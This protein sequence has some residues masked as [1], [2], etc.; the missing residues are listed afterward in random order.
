MDARHLDLQD[1]K[2]PVVPNLPRQQEGCVSP[3]FL[4]KIYRN[5]RAQDTGLEVNRHSKLAPNRGHT[6]QKQS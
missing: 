6:I 4:K 3:F 2:T 1:V 5:F